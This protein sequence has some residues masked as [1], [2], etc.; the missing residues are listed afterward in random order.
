MKMILGYVKETVNT[1]DGPMHT[2]VCVT[3]TNQYSVTFEALVERL[4]L[5]YETKEIAETLFQR[6]TIIG[7]GRD[8]NRSLYEDDYSMETLNGK[9]DV[10]QYLNKKEASD[11]LVFGSFNGEQGWQMYDGESFTPV[12]LYV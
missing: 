12:Y 8:A 2:I 3:F 5:D 7:I 6:G 10:V 1:Y 4:Q 9:Y 11:M